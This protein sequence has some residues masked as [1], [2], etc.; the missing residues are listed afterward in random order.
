[1][2]LP[3][4]LG[5]WSAMGVVVGIDRL[6]H[7]GRRPRSPPRADPV[8]ILRALGRRRLTLFMRRALVRRTGRHVAE[9]GRFLSSAAVKDQGP[10]RVSLLSWSELVV[11]RASAE[12]GM[13]LVFG[14]YALRSAGIDPSTHVLAT[15]LQPASSPS[16]RFAEHRRRPRRGHRQREH[17]SEVCGRGRARG[18]C[19][20]VWRRARCLCTPFNGDFRR[21]RTDHSVGPGACARERPVDV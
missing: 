9:A 16:P 10:G 21:V 8:A 1:M 5:L 19:V 4:K 17:G 13:A 11:I 7:L 15:R 12:G 3:R 2:T 6:R 20:R 18:R 14:E